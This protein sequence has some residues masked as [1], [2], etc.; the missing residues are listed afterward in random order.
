MPNPDP[1]THAV[2]AT[3]AQMMNPQTDFAGNAAGGWP[4]LPGQNKWL[5][6]VVGVGGA[7]ALSTTAAAPLV[8]T[9]LVAAIMFQLFHT[10][11]SQ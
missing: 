11:G 3:V 10:V 6:L 4:T 9:V 8:A 2:N 5:V 7:L 1:S